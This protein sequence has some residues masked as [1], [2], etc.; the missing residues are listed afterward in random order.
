VFGVGGSLALPEIPF[1]STKHQTQN[2]PIKLL[3]A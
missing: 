2:T 1:S 3:R